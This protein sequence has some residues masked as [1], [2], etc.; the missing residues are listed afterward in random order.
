MS[1]NGFVNVSQ[2]VGNIF[3]NTC[4]ND[5]MIYTSSNSQK[6]LIGVNSNSLGQITLSSNLTTINGGFAI[7]SQL[8]MSGLT[9]SGGGQPAN[10][11]SYVNQIAGY[12]NFTNSN[13]YY[14]SSNNSNTSF[15]FMGGSNTAATLTGSGCLTVNSNVTLSNSTGSVTIGSSGSNLLFPANSIPGTAISGFSAQ[16]T[17]LKSQVFNLNQTYGSPTTLPAPTLGFTLYIVYVYIAGICSLSGIVMLSGPYGG[18]YSTL[19]NNTSPYLGSLSYNG[20]NLIY[21][22]STYGSVQ[23]NTWGITVTYVPIA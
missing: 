5:M 9:I 16:A 19:V 15:V 8:N 6:L 12:S 7:N 20:T 11:F 22:S 4:I 13:M 1:L 3:T 2:A 17:S 21:T 10:S 14:V 23:N 18:G